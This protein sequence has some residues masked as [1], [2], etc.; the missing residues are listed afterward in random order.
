MLNF[1]I[2]IPKIYVQ[3]RFEVTNKKIAFFN[4]KLR[5]ICNYDLI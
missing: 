2:D 5:L 3:V 4:L 1:N